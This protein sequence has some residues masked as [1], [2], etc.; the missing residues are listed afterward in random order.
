MGYIFIDKNIYF[1]IKRLI[2]NFKDQQDKY[3]TGFYLEIHSNK[4]GCVEIYVESG[5][6]HNYFIEDMFRKLGKDIIAYVGLYCINFKK[7]KKMNVMIPEIHEKMWEEK[8]KMGHEGVVY[9][10]ES[11]YKLIQL[12]QDYSNLYTH[13]IGDAEYKDKSKELIEEK[14]DKYRRVDNVKSYYRSLF[15][16][17]SKL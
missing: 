13:T 1:N 12:L 17:S 10:N 6:N 4:I 16:Y 5:N 2:D 11:Y 15:M 3:I 7:L 14:I 9:T 8:D